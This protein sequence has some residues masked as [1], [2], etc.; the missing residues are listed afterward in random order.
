[1]AEFI[2]LARRRHNPRDLMVGVRTVLTRLEACEFEGQPGHVNRDSGVSKMEGQLTRTK[3]STSTHTPE[4][5]NVS[6][7]PTA[8]PLAIRWAD[9]DIS[10]RPQGVIEPPIPDYAPRETS[11]QTSEH[12]HTHTQTHTHTHTHTNIRTRKHAHA[13]TDT[14]THTRK[15]TH[16]HTQTHTHTHTHTPH[17]HTHTR[18]RKRLPVTNTHLCTS[19]C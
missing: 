8:R 17:T 14:Y 15:H 4:R 16:T 9:V 5:G 10:G 13:H 2:S 1:M 19:P 7:R 12:K 11:K 3:P 6:T 18:V